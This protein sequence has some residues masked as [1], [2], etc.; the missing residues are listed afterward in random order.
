MKEGLTADSHALLISEDEGN[1]TALEYAKEHLAGNGQVTWICSTANS[2]KLTQ[3]ESLLSLKN[4]YMAAL[5]L[6][7]IT[8]DEKQPF[9]VLTGPLDMQRIERC[10]EYL[11]DPNTVTDYTHRPQ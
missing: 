9:D 7:V 8:R 2:Q 6:L 3:L 11:F 1:Q 10:A 5:N 4:T